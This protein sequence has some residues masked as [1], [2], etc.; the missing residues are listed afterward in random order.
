MFIVNEDNS[1]YCT[2]GDTVHFYVKGKDNAIG[3]DYTFRN[4]DFI[5]FTVYGKKN[6]ENVVLQKMFRAI[7]GSTEA[8]IDLTKDDTSEFD[9]TSKPK[10]YWYDVEL[11]NNFGIQTILGYDEEGAKIFR[12]FPEG[13]EI[14]TDDVP[15]EIPKVNVAM[16]ISITSTE[17][18]ASNAVAL[19][20]L[21]LYK[22]LEQN[23]LDLTLS[24][25]E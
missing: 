17:P 16:D 15:D 3:S 1:I 7:P 23:G 13:D 2:R 14:N 10:D 5:R 8:V 24:Q 21:R 22:I 19:E 18:V 6:C 20:F 4:N 11:I 25:S 12:V 9:F